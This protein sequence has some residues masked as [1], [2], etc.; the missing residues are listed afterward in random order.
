M[1]PTGP[2]ITLLLQAHAAGDEAALR[3]LFSLAYRELLGIA[4]SQRR[5]LNVGSTLDTVGLVHDCFLKL[6][7]GQG[8]TAKDRGHFFAVAASA[9]RHLLIDYA[10]SRA[11]A[12]QLLQVNAALEGLAAVDPRFVTITE[13]R[14]FAG[15]SIP[16]TAEAMGISERTVSRVW[17][18]VLVHLGHQLQQ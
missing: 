1:E 9:M 11:E 13:C 3:Q 2:P 15:L 16:E 18:A 4:R 6:A 10:P 12:D 14:Y 8:V 7:A 17:Q 5:R